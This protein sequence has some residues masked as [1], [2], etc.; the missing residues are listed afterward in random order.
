MDKISH[1]VNHNRFFGIDSE[2][3]SGLELIGKNIDKTNELVDSVNNIKNDDFKKVT[4]EEMNNKYKI[5]DDADFTGSWFGLKKPSLSNEGLAAQV[6][7]NTNDIKSLS[8]NNVIKDYK[9]ISTSFNSDTMKLVVMV[10]YD[11]IKWDVIN[12]NGSFT[13]TIGIKK[14][15]RDPA[16]IKIG[17]WYYITYT[18]I[19]WGVG[20]NIG[21]CRT[22]DF[23]AYEELNDITLGTY[24]KVWAPEFF[25]D[26]G[27]IYIVFSGGIT[28]T[29]VTK[30]T[31]FIQRININDNSIAAA[32]LP[33]SLRI[34]GYSGAFIDSHIFKNCGQYYMVWKNED[35]KTCNIAKCIAIDGTYTNVTNSLFPVTEGAM[36]IKIDGGH[37][38][39][40]DEYENKKICFYETYDNFISFTDKTYINTSDFIG[41]HLYII[42]RDPITP[43]VLNNKPYGIFKNSVS[44]V[45]P[46]NTDYVPAL[47]TIITN[48]EFTQNGDKTQ[49]I[50][51]SDGFYM[52]TG[53][54]S[55]VANNVGNRLIA[56]EHYELSTGKAIGVNSTPACSGDSTGQTVQGVLF[57]KKGTSVRL[58]IKQT[59]GGNLQVSN[60][61]NSLVLTI[62]KL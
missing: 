44:P 57:A 46:N 27:N 38:L 39:Y 19:D 61:Y 60:W 53:S 24:D 59:S 43:N 17:D 36:V 8:N 33:I 55:W 4:H 56:I 6:D 13:P 20:N 37:R 16:L 31:G 47:P 5:N 32:G 22:R 48:S 9:Y 40:L 10:S 58:S 51:P 42:D 11:G 25:N 62:N 18:K 45:V 14:T 50:I 49:I 3:L 15:L 12:K 41:S 52:V 21:F 7:K 1:C 35:L 2:E 30:F 29:G 54:L 23:E 26:N 28:T 34:E